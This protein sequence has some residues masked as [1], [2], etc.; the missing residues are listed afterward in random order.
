MEL[1]EVLHLMTYGC[2]Q[3]PILKAIKD[4][5]NLIKATWKGPKS[6]SAEWKASPDQFVNGSNL[7]HY[8]AHFNLDEVT[9]YLLTAG[10]NIESSTDEWYKTPLAWAAD[11]GSA[12]TLD[13][14]LKKGA[15][16]DAEVGGGHTAL[17]C[18]AHGGSSNA[19]ERS[20]GY[21][22]TVELLIASGADINKKGEKGTPLHVAISAKNLV[23]SEVLKKHKAME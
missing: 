22:K 13:I 6:G 14:L 4:N 10:V 1:T 20:D 3:E 12:I 18:V 23:V 7:L 19:R 17:H 16:V 9:N 21:Q 2:D 5:P 8:A 15:K 11:G